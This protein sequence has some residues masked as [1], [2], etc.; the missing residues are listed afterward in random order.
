MKMMENSENIKFS[1]RILPRS[2]IFT[3]KLQILRKMIKFDLFSVN[4]YI[5]QWNA[6]PSTDIY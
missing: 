1:S 6:L 4:W 3:E 2:V 5:F